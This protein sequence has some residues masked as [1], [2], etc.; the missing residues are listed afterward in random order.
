MYT[1]YGHENA[2]TAAAW[3]PLGDFFVTGGADSVVL[4]WKSNIN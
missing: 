2:S 4:A 3:S 1:L